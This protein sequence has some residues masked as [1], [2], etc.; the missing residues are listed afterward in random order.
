MADGWCLVSV[1]ATSERQLGD[2]MPCFFLLLTCF[3]VV[4]LLIK[5]EASPN[6]VAHEPKGLDAIAL[7][8]VFFFL[9]DSLAEGKACPIDQSIRQYCIQLPF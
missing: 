3:T 7:V 4:L 9:I 5:G 8:C 2:K 6:D 1:P